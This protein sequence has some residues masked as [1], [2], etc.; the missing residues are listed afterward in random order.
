MA[1]VAPNLAVGGLKTPA[2]DGLTPIRLARQ[3]SIGVFEAG[4]V[5]RHFFAVTLT[6]AVLA[7]RVVMA[8]SARIL[9]ALAGL[10]LGLAPCRLGAAGAAIDIAPVAIAAQQRL[11]VAACAAEESGYVV[12]RRIP[13][14]KNWTQARST[15][16]LICEP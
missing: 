1:S 12:H 4:T 15:A 11:A 10:A 7:G 3:Y 6:I 9:I 13:A 16:I 2:T 8:P 5:M 14:E